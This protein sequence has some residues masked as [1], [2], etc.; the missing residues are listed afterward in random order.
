MTWLCLTDLK[1]N[2]K[3]NYFVILIFRKFSINLSKKIYLSFPFTFKFKFFNFYASKVFYVF[4]GKIVKIY[5]KKGKEN[6]STSVS[7]LTFFYFFLGH[8]NVYNRDKSI[9]SCRFLSYSESNFRILLWY[10]INYRCYPMF[11][12]NEI[13]SQTSFFL[14]VSFTVCVLCLS[15]HFGWCSLR[16]SCGSTSSSNCFSSYW[17]CRWWTHRFTCC[18][19][20]LLRCWRYFYWRQQKSTWNTWWRFSCWSSKLKALSYCS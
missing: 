10:S 15:R 5:M 7:Q 12:N 6:S 19:Q 17:T 8:L 18:I 3:I 20:F 11:T 13:W 2:I 9:S 4:L 14:F 16:C 1:S